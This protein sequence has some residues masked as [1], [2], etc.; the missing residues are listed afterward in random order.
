MPY[1]HLFLRF[2]FQDDSS[3]QICDTCPVEYNLLALVTVC[4]SVEP[5][6]QTFDILLG[7]PV[8]SLG[9]KFLKENCVCLSDLRVCQFTTHH[10]HFNFN[11]QVIF[12]EEYNYSISYPIHY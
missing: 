6:S 5:K 1:S 2:R 7:S 4:Q 10:I 12:S 3:T 11:V 8:F 9:A